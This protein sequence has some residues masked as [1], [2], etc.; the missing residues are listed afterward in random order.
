MRVPV[1]DDT[2]EV[3][4]PEHLH[5]GLS[6]ARTAASVGRGG[7]GA[8][9][10]GGA[11]AGTTIGAAADGTGAAVCASG[12]LNKRAR[13]EHERCVAD[14]MGDEGYAGSGRTQADQSTTRGRQTDGGR[15]NRDNGPPTASSR[16]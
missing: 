7:S 14:L 6:R 4:L 10:G 9:R 8:G 2:Q 11:A 15:N 3:V 5:R 1:N 13:L 16:P 12:L